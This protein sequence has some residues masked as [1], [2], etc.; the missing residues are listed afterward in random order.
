MSYPHH[1]TP[2]DQLIDQ[3]MREVVELK[4]RLRE[5][6]EQEMANQELIGRLRERQMHLEAEIQ[7]Y[8]EIAEQTCNVCHIQYALQNFN[9]TPSLLLPAELPW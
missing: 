2:R 4:E 6:E 5:L 8:K 3:L 9:T 7:E 1:L